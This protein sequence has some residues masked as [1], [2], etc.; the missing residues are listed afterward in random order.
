MYKRQGFVV[1]SIDQRGFG[2]STGTVRVM[3]PEFEGEDLIQILDWAEA[4]LDYLRYRD[5][6]ELP[7]DLNPNLVAGAIGGSYGGGYQILIH[8]QDPRRRLDALVPDITWYDLRYS[9]NPGNVIKTGWD[10]VLVA[11]GEAGSTGQGNGG[12]DPIIRETLARGAT[13]NRFPEAGLDFIYYHSPAYR[14]TGEPVFVAE[15]P[16]LLNYQIDPPAYDVAPTPFA[17]VDVL[18][19]QGMRDTLFNF[20]EAWRNFECLKA[21]GGDVR[22]LTHQTGHILPAEAPDEAQPA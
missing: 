16:D 1:I 11:G 6:P 13:L 18:L 14:C 2:E 22:L 20:N 8:G 10:L 15:D 3:D 4:N 19:T 12:L 5:E 17:E 9:L 21:S 7:D